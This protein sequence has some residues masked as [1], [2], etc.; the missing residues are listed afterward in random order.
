MTI[1]YYRYDRGEKRRTPKREW[2]EKEEGGRE[3]GRRKEE[4]RRRREEVRT[5]T[6]NSIIFI[7]R[8]WWI[9]FLCPFFSALIVIKS[10]PYDTALSFPS[11][12]HPSSNY[13]ID[14]M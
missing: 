7:C 4:G 3:G 13:F 1:G 12:L 8:W 6:N 11:P 10:L 9:S 14:I 2:E 5:R